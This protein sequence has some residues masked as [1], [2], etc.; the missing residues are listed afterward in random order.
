M[1]KLTSHQAS[2]PPS[3]GGAG[4]FSL[5]PYG[6]ATLAAQ[7]MPRQAGSP[8]QAA[9]AH[10]ANYQPDGSCLGIYYNDGLSVDRSRYRPCE[11]CLLAAG[12]R[13]EYF[14]EIIIPMRM[15]RETAEAKTQADKKEAAVSA[16]LKPHKLIPS[17]T[18]AKKMCKQCKRI[19]V[20]GI[21]KYCERCALK[22]KLAFTCKSKQS[23][24]GLNRRKS[25]NSP[26]GAE[27]LTKAEN[28]V[29]YP[30]LKRRFWGLVFRQSKGLQRELCHE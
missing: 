15:S 26:I 6:L 21:A 3:N 18:E 11:K 23:K 1:H 28:Q 12:K 2:S 25:E 29:G 7:L 13:C 10:C 17:K 4:S 9:K 27:A 5:N 24:R 22:R 20:G 14:E 30:S 19:E 8:L 16:Y